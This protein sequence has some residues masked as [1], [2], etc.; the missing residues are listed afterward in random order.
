MSHRIEG[1]KLGL[2]LAAVIASA[3]PAGNSMA[4]AWPNQKAITVVNPASPG[5]VLDNLLRSTSEVVA[6]KIGQSIIVDS[7]SGGAGVLAAQAVINAP[8]DGYVIASNYAS[9]VINPYA[10]Q[11]LPYDTFRDF[12]PVTRLADL[13]VLLLAP[14]SAPYSDVPSLIKYA[15]ENPGKVNF[16]VPGLGGSIHFGFETFISVARISVESIPYRGES[17]VLPDLLSGRLTLTAMSSGTAKP[18]IDS[19]KVKVLAAFSEKRVPAFPNVPTIAEQ[20][21]AYKPLLTWYG[22]FMRAGTPQPV[23][24]RLAAEYHAALQ[25]PAVKALLEAAG[26]VPVGSTP[27]EFAAQLRDEYQRYGDVIRAT[28]FKFQ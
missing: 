26:L 11:T 10:I 28:G 5:G 24:E 21:P 3:L 18:H 6:R 9:H 22:L 7:K 19:G 17:Q 14:S 2:A 16:G 25:D 20:V 23:V 12:V 8:P 4:Q 15:R 1:L 27:A 13:T